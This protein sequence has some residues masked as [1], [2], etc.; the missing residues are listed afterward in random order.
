MALPTLEDLKPQAK[1]Q[2][3]P[4]KKTVGQS[5]ME[6]ASPTIGAVK[7]VGS[8]LAGLS[9]L[10]QRGIR[11]VTQPITGKQKPIERPEGLR[12]ALS[13]KNK[14]EKIGFTAEQIGEFF[15]P[16]A[17]GLKAGKGAG[18]LSKMA[19]GAG[20]MGGVTAAQ[21]GEIGSDALVGA[22]IGAAF[23]LAGAALKSVTG[24]TK[25]L[26]RRALGLTANQSKK[27]T[28][29]AK[30]KDPETGKAIYKGVED[31]AVKKGIIGKGMEA[32]GREQMLERAT[33]ALESTFNKKD[34][35]VNQMQG[36]LK[37]EFKPI[38]KILQS[39]L[40][41]LNKQAGG[42]LDDV[43]KFIDSSAKKK[44]LG[45][46][47]IEKIRKIADDIAFS[48]KES[49]LANRIRDLIRPLRGALNKIDKTGKLTEVNTDIRL[50]KKLVGDK[51][52]LTAAAQ[53]DPVGK[54]LTSGAIS[55]G[56]SSFVPGVGTALAP[57]IGARALTGIPQ[58][59]GPL[60]RG[61]QAGTQS[62]VLPAVSQLGQASL[63]QMS[64]MPDPQEVRE[65]EQNFRLPNGA[66]IPG[67]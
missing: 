30:T 48:E 18:L 6:L 42:A 54:L 2:S 50:L 7:G 46:E 35:I 21:E 63:S 57:L 53:K 52:F 61:I 24:G 40:K 16:G 36:T 20:T 5:F 43:V 25:G 45:A 27:L 66:P 37:N 19:A 67:L 9:E 26:V 11:A 28:P 38:L 4:Q 12:S 58:I 55:T 33:S 15:I 29:I 51:G 41:P 39:K 3:T 34:A 47:A 31:F 8:T 23:P 14:G 17:L 22:G 56:A 32:P 62:G 1:F 10:G 60:A 13:P 59:A 49:L 64:R 44:Y 65:P